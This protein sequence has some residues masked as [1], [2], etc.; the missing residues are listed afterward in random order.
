MT[1]TKNS[2]TPHTFGSAL[3]AHRKASGL[4]QKALADQ[5]GVTRPY[6]SQVENDVDVFGKETMLAA[7]V[8]LRLTPEQVADLDR[9]RTGPDALAPSDAKRLADLEARVES[10]AQHL[11][12]LALEVVEL[13]RALGQGGTG[14]A[15]R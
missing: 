13:R 10:Q 5:I 4:S 8:A 9:L 2:Q 12:D 15:E 7:A 3:L 1:T 6:V 14:A 11:A